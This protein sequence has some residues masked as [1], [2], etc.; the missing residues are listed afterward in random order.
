MATDYDAPRKTDDDDTQSIE[1]LKERTAS[2]NPPSLDVDESDASVEFLAPEVV[3][4]DTDVVIVPAQQDEFT[5]VE[6]FIVKHNSQIAKKTK[7]GA[8]CVECAN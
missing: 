6:C 7:L 5:C 8:I 1:V 2:A 3:S 4:E